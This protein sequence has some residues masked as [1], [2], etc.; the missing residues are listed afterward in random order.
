MLCMRACDARFGDA[1]ARR[2]SL[3]DSRILCVAR[4]TLH[5]GRR[6]FRCS[7]YATWSRQISLP[8]FLLQEEMS[9]RLSAVIVIRYV[10]MMPRQQTG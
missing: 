3:W 4:H 9:C 8:G 10:A 2:H 5:R 6:R 7:A 1:R